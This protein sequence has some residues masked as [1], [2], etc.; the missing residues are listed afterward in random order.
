VTRTPTALHLAA[1]ALGLCLA[2]P[3]QAQ[4]LY[5]QTVELPTG[6]EYDSNPALTST[7]SAGVTRWRVSPS[8]TL[9]R[10]SD[11]DELRLKLGAT[12]ERSSNTA[13]SR[14]RNDLHADTQWQHASERTA[15]VLGAGV[16]QSALRDTLLEETG[17]VFVAD[18]TQTTRRLNAS[19]THEIDALHS[20]SAGANARWNRFTVGTLPDSRQVAANVEISRAL[21]PG[22]SVFASGNVSRY[23]P[24]G[25]AGL[26]SSTMRGV[27]VGYRNRL[28]GD[29]WAWEVSGG[30]ARYTG[31]FSDTMAQAAA[32][33]SY[34]GPRWSASLG[35][36]RQP[37]VD[38]LRGSFSPNQQLRVGAEYAL[39]E[40]TRIGFD[41]SSVRTSGVRTSTAR[42][43][44]LRVSTELSPLWRLSLQ[45]RH[46]QVERANPLLN[47]RA[48]STVGSV[49]L[50]YSHPDF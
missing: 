25:F 39:T 38:N 40:L 19:V 36:S 8:Y 50:T 42:V 35:F 49:L 31:P 15:Y 32:Q 21:A 2:W 43:V 26:A 6:L 7:P 11:A 48:N 30:V 37:V 5:Q 46:R 27:M 14:N 44:G 18:G 1:A 22:V 10:R 12:F 13:L 20:F 3:L 45:L 34:E 4:S 17:Q 28:P 16:D 9:L 23:V 41:A 24:E 33:V 47:T 29:P